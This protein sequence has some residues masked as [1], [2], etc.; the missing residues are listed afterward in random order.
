MSTKKSPLLLLAVAGMELS[1]LCAVAVLLLPLAGVSPLLLPQA[2]AAFL[3]GAVL[4]LFIQKNNWRIVYR[5]VLHIFVLFALLL[6]SLYSFN[7]GGALFWS[8]GWIERLLQGPHDMEQ[9]LLWAA[10]LF[11]T[12]IFWGGGVCLARRSLSYFATTSRFDVGI[13][14]FILIFIIVGV[15]DFPAIPV[16]LLLFPFFLTS[17]IGIALARN[18]KGD[19]RGAFQL[20]YRGNAPVLAFAAVVLLGGA[21]VI[22]FLLPFLT[23]AAEAGYS[24]MV[25]YGTPLSA[26]LGRL[27]LFIF[28]YGRQLSRSAPVEETG[29]SFLVDPEAVSSGEAGFWDLLIGWASI[30]LIAAVGL[31]AVGW[32]LWHLLRWLLSGAEKPGKGRGIK[33]ILLL[34]LHKWRSFW[35][36]MQQWFRGWLFRLTAGQ[37]EGEASRLFGRLMVWGRWSGFNRVAA[38]TPREY[39]LVLGQHF[40]GAQA[41][42]ELIIHCFHDEVYGKMT[43]D[44][45]QKR[46][47][48]RAWR[49]LCSPRRWPA[50]F[51][52]RL[53]HGSIMELRQ[54]EN[55]DLK[56]G[57][58]EKGDKKAD[59]GGDI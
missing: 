30:G 51:Y 39:G 2:L 33:E 54:L 56:S 44:R 38:E 36:R 47:L 22:L 41:E 34:F 15:T 52:K 1:W 12:L 18:Q 28:G 35:R 24:A 48:R 27:I 5:M 21:T 32:G 9:G 7:H 58:N 8:R 50:R 13:T 57:I 49:R 25:Q 53:T 20:K 40:P 19:E 46:V 14:A 16:M 6:H 45:G 23:L 37:R 10:V 55:N 29:D 31:F 17:M 3:G 26:L 43:L 59:Y 11:V 4:T 42:I